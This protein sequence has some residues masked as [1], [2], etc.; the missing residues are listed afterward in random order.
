MT[1]EL[2]RVENIKRYFPVK[3]NFG[4]VQTV[5]KAIDNV[6]LTINKGETIG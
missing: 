5:V 2:I 1:N 6:S 4:Q 3:N